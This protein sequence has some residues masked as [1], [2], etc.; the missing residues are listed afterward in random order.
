M[1]AQAE[2]GKLTLVSK[3]VELDLLLTE[4]FTEMCVLAGNKVHVHL[5]DIDQVMVNGDRDRLKQV[6]L[7]LVANAIQYTPQG[8]DVFLSMSKIGEQ[9]RD[10]INIDDICEA[11]MRTVEADIIEPINLCTGRGVSMIDLAKMM[12]VISG[13]HKPYMF[14]CDKSMPSGVQYRVGNPELLKTIYSPPT[15]LEVE[16]G[17]IFRMSE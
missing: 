11:I 10:W 2:S 9:V 13:N 17:R 6:F 14:G 4:V 5:N 15:I 12:L 16:L 7:N 3:P 8:G 1:L